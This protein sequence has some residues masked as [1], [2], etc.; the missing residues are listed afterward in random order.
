MSSV[1]NFKFA[2]IWWLECKKTGIISTGLLPKNHGGIG[3]T[4]KLMWEN[5]ANKKRRRYEARILAL[6]DSEVEMNLIAVDIDGKIVPS[7]EK[8]FPKEILLDNKN[9][10][11]DKKKKKN[12]QKKNRREAE[13]KIMEVPFIH[14][15]S[16]IEPP[17]R[18]STPIPSPAVDVSVETIIDVDEKITHK[19]IIKY[20]L[21]FKVTKRDIEYH[22]QMGALMKATYEWQMRESECADDDIHIDYTAPGSERVEI[23]PGTGIYFPSNVLL[24]IERRAQKRK[25]EGSDWKILI[26]EA[27]L[28]VYGGTIIN[29]SATGSRSNSRPPINAQLFKALY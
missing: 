13:A 19:P 5:P 25:G 29:Y 23:E 12:Q 26:R 9:I 3:S 18:S 11:D 17:I 21:P 27:L 8:I 20:L 15:F 24:C 4:I 28:E 10:A 7:N 22:D 1:C 6:G 2:L 16:E 14:S